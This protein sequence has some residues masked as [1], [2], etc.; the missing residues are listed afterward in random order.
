[1]GFNL[2]TRFHPFILSGQLDHR[3]ITINQETLMKQ[4]L[5]AGIY[6]VVTV[7]KIG[8]VESFY[9]TLVAQSSGNHEHLIDYNDVIEWIHIQRFESPRRFI[10][11]K[12]VQSFD[13]GL[14]SNLGK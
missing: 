12:L 6:Q 8:R 4:D 2:I 13:L 10:I 11:S 14:T 1:M 7:D 3:L 9:P 5:K